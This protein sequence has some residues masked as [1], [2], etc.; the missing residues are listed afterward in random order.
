MCVLLLNYTL[1]YMSRFYAVCVCVW[2]RQALQ[3]KQEVVTP[4]I[5][6]LFWYFWYWNL[7]AR[8]ST[9]AGFMCTAFCSVLSEQFLSVLNSHTHSKVLYSMFLWSGV[10]S[11]FQHSSGTQVFQGL[12]SEHMEETEVQRAMHSMDAST[13][14]EPKRRCCGWL[15][16]RCPCPPRGLLASLITK[17]DEAKSGT[18]DL[19]ITDEYTQIHSRPHRWAL[20][21]SF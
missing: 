1:C 21:V 9:R 13:N 18:N 5:C 20:N 16:R 4:L 7:N 3:N 11:C 17:G 19:P 14:T 12:L 2:E 10:Y 15:R 8:E 6:S